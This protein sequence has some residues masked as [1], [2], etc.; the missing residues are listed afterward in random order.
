MNGKLFYL[1]E[2]ELFSILTQILLENNRQK[3]FFFSIRSPGI[4][5]SSKTVKP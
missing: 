4:F 5:V 3:M 2:N 1:I